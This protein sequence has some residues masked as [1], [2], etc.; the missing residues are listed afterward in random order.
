MDEW[1]DEQDNGLP[2]AADSPEG[3]QPWV[4]RLL[5]RRLGDVRVHNTTQAG[6]LARRLGARAFTAGRHV[7][8][9]PD[10]LHPRTPE[11]VALLAHELTHAA[12]QAG[13][14]P[15]TPPARTGAGPLLTAHRSAAVQRAVAGGSDA[16]EGRARG[17]EAAAT[18]QAQTPRRPAAPPAPPV[19][20]VAEAVYRLMVRDLLTD[21]ERMV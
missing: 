4:E 17:V 14:P 15:I 18:I 8:V 9:R 11:S 10:L 3:L 2:P 20:E 5:G 6:D 1:G 12:E 7:Y 16:A 19:E 21:Q 13:A